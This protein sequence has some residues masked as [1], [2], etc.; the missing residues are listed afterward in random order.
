MEKKCLWQLWLQLGRVRFLV[1]SPIA[2]AAGV[3]CATA[4]NSAQG[5]SIRLFLV[6]QV[7]VSATHMLTHFFN[8]YYDLAADTLHEFP[9]PW[10]GGSRVLVAGSVRPET[11]FRLG[12]TLTALMLALIL[13]FIPQTETQIL[14][15]AVVV[16]AIGYSAPPLQLANRGLGEATVMLVLNILVPVFGYSLFRNP[17]SSPAL[18]LAMTPPA[19]VEFVRMMVMNM[20]DVVGDARARKLTLV[21][22]LGLDRSVFIHMLGIA[23]AYIT[24]TIL[25]LLGRVSRVVFLLEFSTLPMGAMICW[26]LYYRQEYLSLTKFYNLPFVSTLHNGFILIAADV[27]LVMF[28]NLV[29]KSEFTNL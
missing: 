26:R 11:S 7:F 1:Y 27:G 19:M 10:T 15:T 3:T 5:F 9:S 8:E 24:L 17:E 16:L 13:T 20:A 18:L 14:A 2:Y 4:N 23:A 12:C 21:V 22:R 6:G 25:F 29:P 28:S